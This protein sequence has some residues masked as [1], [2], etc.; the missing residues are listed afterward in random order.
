MGMTQFDVLDRNLNLKQNYLLEASAGTGKTFSIENIVVRLLVEEEIPLDQILVV[1]FTRA[2]TRDLK[3][4]IRQNINFVLECLENETENVP[5]FIQ[6]YLEKDSSELYRI[7]K[8]L[9]KALLCFDQAQIF[10]I[11]G[12][13]AKMLREHLFES[14]IAT[15][16]LDTEESIARSEV[17]R[18]IRDFFRTEIRPGRYS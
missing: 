1:T 13:C 12:F 10:T 15:G 18:V 8:K 3:L 6:S 2:A 9:K 17:I 4:R 5:D 14:D 16:T 7:Q 11:H